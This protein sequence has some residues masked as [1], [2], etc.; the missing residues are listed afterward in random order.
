MY[1][2]Q[3]HNMHSR[4]QTPFPA[5][6]SAERYHFETHGYVILESVFSDEEVESLKAAVYDVFD[7][8]QASQESGVNDP[9]LMGANTHHFEPGKMRRLNGMGFSHERFIDF[10]THPYIVGMCEEVTGSAVRLNETT[11]IANVGGSQGQETFGWH[12]GAD[13]QASCHTKHNL[14]HCDF[15]KTLVNLTDFGPDN[16]GTLCLPGTHKLDIPYHELRDFANENAHIA[17]QF[18]APKG[19]VFLFAESLIHATGENRSDEERVLFISS[20]CNRML[21]NWDRYEGIDPLHEE[22]YLAQ[23]PEHLRI[24]FRGYADWTRGQ[25]YRRNL[26]DAIE[27]CDHALGSWRQRPA[28]EFVPCSVEVD[29]C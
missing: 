13:V 28:V 20:F 11:A 1:K 12:R 24:H 6:S 29:A 18:I 8:F 23:F 15:V 14:F 4:I 26:A 7:R 19:S 10:N 25:R 27:P 2:R 9:S 16:G 3:D 5:L 22:A 21:P 17:H